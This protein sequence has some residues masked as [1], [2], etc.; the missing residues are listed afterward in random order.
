ML[1]MFGEA[2]MRAAAWHRMRK[3]GAGRQSYA[4]LRMAVIRGFVLGCRAWLF[5]ILKRHV[6]KET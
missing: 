5:L 2:F 3:R 4:M 1:F 6:A